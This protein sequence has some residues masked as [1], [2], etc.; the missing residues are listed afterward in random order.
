MYRGRSISKCVYLIDGIKRAVCIEESI[1]RKGKI[2]QNIVG[3]L[4]L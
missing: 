2:G 3:E 1:S 4:T